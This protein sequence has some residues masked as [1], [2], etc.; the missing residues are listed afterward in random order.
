MIFTPSMSKLFQLDPSLTFNT[1]T[2]KVPGKLYF[3]GEYAILEAGHSA[4]LFA[5]NQYLTCKVSL[6]HF[7][8]HG[9]ITTT[10]KDLVPLNYKRDAKDGTIN[11][12]GETD[13]QKAQALTKD[14]AY[15]IEAIQII[16]H[17]IQELGRP[18]QD[19]RID[20]TS[21]LIAE[22]GSK[23]GLGS[24]AAVTVSTIKAL[25]TFYGICPRDPLTIFKLA[26]IALMRAGSNGSMGDVASITYG[27]WVY[28]ESLD[29]EW[30]KNELAQQ[31][32]IESLLVKDWPKLKIEYLPNIPNLKLLVGWTQKGASTQNLVADLK[33]LVVNNNA[34]Y[35]DFLTSSKK[36]VYSM[37]SAF[38]DADIMQIQVEMANYRHLLL[39]LSKHYPIN[40][41]TE[42]L[43]RL[44]EIAQAYQFEG[45]SSGAGGGDCGI[46]I[47]EK[48]LK[49]KLLTD[50]W[51]RSDIIPLD[52]EVAPKQF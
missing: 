42:R 39:K 50:E 35:Q 44:I 17:L 52:L 23:Y 31:T 1:T 7:P 40:I 34:A 36:C 32:S 15:V 37:K 13:P 6:T 46:A 18:L 49:S 28:Y 41:E 10:L 25:L 33:Q 12:N 22:D 9:K 30:L 8:L 29:R 45:K 21:D 11:F 26:A 2:E 20:Y 51:K 4:I 24:S 3:A 38:L 19:Y 27:H 14:W 43:K 5:V 48:T 16:E 47:G